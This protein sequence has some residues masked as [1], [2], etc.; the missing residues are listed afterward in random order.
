ME[1]PP[2]AGDS[3]A[4]ELLVASFG[5]DGS[6]H[7]RDAAWRSIFGT[8]GAWQRL[9]AQDQTTVD[10]A[11]RE[12]AQGNLVTHQVVSTRLTGATEP[13]PTLLHFLPTF[14]ARGEVVSV[15][16]T[17][18]LLTQPGSWNVSQTRRNRMETL[19][20]MSMAIAHD[21]N[22][23]LSGIL[24]HTELLKLTAV[25][26]NGAREHVQ[27]IERAAL[28]GAAIVRKIQQYVRQ[29]KQNRYEH[30]FLGDILD[31]C[32]MLTKPYWYNEPRR[33]GIRIELTHD[34]APSPPILGAGHELRE[35]F[36][37]MILNAAQAMPRGG[38]IKLTAKPDGPRHVLVTVAD[39]GDGMPAHVR[40]RIFEPMFSTKGENGTGMGLAVAYGI[41]RA[42]EADVQVDSAPGIG[43]RFRIRFPIAD[44]APDVDAAPASEPDQIDARILIVD[45]EEM[46]RTVLARLLKLRGYR[47]TQVGSAA[48]ALGLLASGETFDAVI[49]DLGMPE[50]NG[51]DFALAA[52]RVDGPPPIVL[53]SGDTEPGTP[54]ATIAAILA[55][56]FQIDQV[57]QTLRRVIAKE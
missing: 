40:A 36:V 9:E 15:A 51:R 49:T 11:L 32:A 29:E 57:D 6:V 14:G 52:A 21:L 2:T 26:M 12:A 33:H 45:D 53:L 37:N 20:R 48:A 4:T 24:G 5:L 25:S 46:V 43:T 28:D 44:D 30:L 47:T 17:G 1:S 23:L 41:L 27:T 50:M 55:K 7:H 3:L 22:N 38:R 10:E 56:P 16:V 19:G 39:T 13:T 18:E 8:D 34:F 31:E 35:V 54:D 42:H